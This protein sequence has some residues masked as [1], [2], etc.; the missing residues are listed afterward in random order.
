MLPLDPVVLLLN[1]PALTPPNHLVDP[2]DN[3]DPDESIDIELLQPMGNI[4]THH[5]H[6]RSMRRLMKSEASQT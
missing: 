2:G 1:I 3:L 4:E 6:V 5:L